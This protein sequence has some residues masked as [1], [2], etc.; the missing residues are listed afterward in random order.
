MM[1]LKVIEINHIQMTVPSDAEE[2]SKTFYGSV[3]GLEQIPKPDALKSRGGAWYRSGQIEFH[4]SIEDASD[5][6]SSRRH[7][8]FIVA[9]LEE[10][11]R[12]LLQAGVEI[13][14]DKRPISGWQRFYVRDPGGNQVEIA[15]RVEVNND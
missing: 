7:V 1:A 12:T 14:P 8:C 13:I 4:L 2:A 10:A 3:L 9:G 15:E 6:R 11:E 5:N